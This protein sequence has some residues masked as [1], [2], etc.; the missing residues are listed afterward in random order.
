MLASIGEQFLKVVCAEQKWLP[1]GKMAREQ[2]MAIIWL[3]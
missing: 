2:K 3:L 1:T